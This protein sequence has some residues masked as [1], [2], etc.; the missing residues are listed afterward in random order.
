MDF[1]LTYTLIQQTPIIHFQHDQKG[2]TLRATEVKPKL[3][4]FIIEKMR[5]TKK[6]KEKTERKKIKEAYK[7][8]FIGDTDALN[9][10][11]RI[12]TDGLP[13]I[14]RAIDLTLKKNNET[15]IKKKKDLDKEIK[16]QINGMY[17]GNM[18]SAKGAA[19]EE[20][21]RESYKETV[22]YNGR[23]QIHLRIICFVDDLRKKI[24]EYMEE[25]FF[26]N[27]FG[28]RQ[29][30]GFGGFTAIKLLGGKEEKSKDPIK[31]LSEKG[32]RFFYAEIKGNGGYKEMLDHAKNVY[33]VM[34]GGYNHTKFDSPDSYIK[35]YIQRYFIDDYIGENTGSDKAFIKNYKR[36]LVPESIKE[37]YDDYVFSRAM[38]GLADYFEFRDRVRG[39]RVEIFSLGKNDFDVERFRSPVTIKIIGNKL[40]FLFGSFDAI[41]DKTFYFAP[42]PEC[43]DKNFDKLS[44]DQK[45]NY[46]TKNVNKT[47]RYGNTLIVPI[48]TM[49]KFDDEDIVFFINVFCEYFMDESYKLSNFRKDQTISISS[50]LRLIVPKHIERSF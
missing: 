39:G 8:W 33:A 38:L 31:L 12:V 15:D 16:K 27:N 1:Q 48:Q 47:D 29:S 11:M 6:L 46:I 18:V 45:K 21:V 35:G 36:K 49:K 3:D 7:E 28:T 10:K 22:F 23:E 42:N 2:A 50:N 24:E 32:Y 43:L 9:Y 37:R 5:W 44:Y 20:A 40:I 17:F 14:S 30:K 19:F 25:F 26:V 13:E 4:K 34:K 41:C